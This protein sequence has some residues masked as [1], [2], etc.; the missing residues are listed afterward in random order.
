MFGNRITGVSPVRN[1]FNLGKILNGLSRGLNVAN[2]AIPLYQEA[3]PMFNNAKNAFSMVRTFISSDNKK[4]N[5]NE[6]NSV[7]KEG[8]GNVNNT[9][10][11]T[12]INAPRFFV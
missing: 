10:N 12:N 5:N 11:K 9:T 6:I 4:A 7:H 3:K 2:R 1:G 8:L